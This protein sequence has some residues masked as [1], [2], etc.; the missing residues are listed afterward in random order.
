MLGWVLHPTQPVG[1]LGCVLVSLCSFVFVW[2]GCFVWVCVCGVR[3]GVCAVV[4]LCCLCVVCV[5]CVCV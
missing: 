1:V 3:V 2:C 4:C 5:V